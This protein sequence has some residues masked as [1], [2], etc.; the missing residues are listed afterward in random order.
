MSFSVKDCTANGGRLRRYGC[1]GHVASPG[2][3][4]CGTGRSSIGKNGLPVTRS[5]TKMKPCLVACATTS[6]LR[7]SWRSV[8]SFGDCGRSKSHRSW[9]TSWW[10]HSRLP[11]RASSA[12][13]LLANRFAPWRLP[14]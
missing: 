2:T 14:P 12:T 3:S 11:V 10:C 7:P 8:S 9:C 6:T 13:R 4:V 5:N 1:V